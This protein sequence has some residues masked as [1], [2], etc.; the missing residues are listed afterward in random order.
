MYR[1][2]PPEGGDRESAGFFAPHFDAAQPRSAVKDGAL[3]D[4][5]PAKGIV[6]LSQMS[7]LLYLSDGHSGGHTTFYP[8]GVADDPNARRVRVSPRRGAALVFWHG[9][10]PL[11]PL[12]EG[13]PL[14]AEDRSAKYV[15]RTDVLFATD[16]PLVNDTEWGSSSYVN[17]MLI[18]AAKMK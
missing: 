10:H 1:Y 9:R 16:P 18:A 5:E 6:R 15:I 8:D 7:V 4:D 14:E 2:A 17:A 3:I 11:S 13:A 12:H